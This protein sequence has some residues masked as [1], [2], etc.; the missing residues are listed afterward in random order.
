MRARMKLIAWTLREHARAG[1]RR[2]ARRS[3]GVDARGGAR[4]GADSAGTILDLDIAP[5]GAMTRVDRRGRT[6]FHWACHR[7]SES[8]LALFKTRG[9]LDRVVLE[10]EAATRRRRRPPR[11][12]RDSSENITVA[13][14]DLS[15]RHLRPRTRIHR[16]RGRRLRRRPRIHRASPPRSL[17][18]SARAS[19]YS[20]STS[21]P[22]DRGRAPP[23]SV[24]PPIQSAVRGVARKSV[25]RSVSETRLAR[26]RAR[27]RA[28]V[29]S[30]RETLAR[31]PA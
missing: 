22:D 6:A 17:S 1:G 11:R 29:P 8:T 18:P 30:L 24:S 14:S 13:R 12:S 31:T 4:F 21:S 23:A 26:T 16:R 27:V 25:F 7:G 5:A 15:R 28:G 2:G 19:S 20:T 9:L 3:N 10:H